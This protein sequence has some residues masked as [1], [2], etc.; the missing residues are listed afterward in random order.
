MCSLF[1]QGEGGAK[2]TPWRE[3]PSSVMATNKRGQLEARGGSPFVF[4]DV[5]C[6]I[7]GGASV[8]RDT[9]CG[10]QEKVGSESSNFPDSD[11]EPTMR[12]TIPRKRS[13]SGSVDIDADIEDDFAANLYIRMHEEAIDQKST[14]DWSR[15]GEGPTCL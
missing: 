7:V 5:T 9:D 15:V 13:Q 4:P 8:A 10:V 11:N 6:P 2:R 3:E 14:T 12:Q 1:L